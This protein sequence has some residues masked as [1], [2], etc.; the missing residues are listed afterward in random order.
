MHE[1]IRPE[2][3]YR[4]AFNQMKKGEKKSRRSQRGGAGAADFAQYVYGAAPAQVANPVHGNEILMRNPAGY[5]GGGRSRSGAGRGGSMV[6]D[7]AVP[8]VLL[9]VQQYSRKSRRSTK[10]RKTQRK[11]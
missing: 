4:I 11:R 10:K 2:Y 1:K 5:V 8:A 3:I 9:G 6:V 7:L